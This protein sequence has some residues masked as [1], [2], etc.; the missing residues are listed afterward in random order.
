MQLTPHISH[1]GQVRTHAVLQHILDF[2]PSGKETV[3]SIGDLRKNEDGTMSE[4]L[5]DV[6]DWS[7]GVMSRANERWMAM[8]KKKTCKDIE[9]VS[10]QGI[11]PGS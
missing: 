8:I 5:L 4:E 7:Q 3:P 2:R 11:D 1:I 10:Q 9:G 6:P